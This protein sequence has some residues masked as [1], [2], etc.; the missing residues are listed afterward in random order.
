MRGLHPAAAERNGAD[1]PAGRADLA[2]QPSR[3]DDI[4]DRIPGADFVERH[5]VRRS[6]MHPPLGLGELSEDADGMADG[7]G[8]EGRLFQSIADRSPGYVAVCVVI[9]FVIVGL[10]FMVMMAMM[11]VVM[12][13]VAVI[14][15]VVR[16]VISMADGEAAA[17]EDAVIMGNKRAVDALDQRAKL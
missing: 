2:D 12:I 3:R 13:P 7:F 11:V 8:I 15:R 9:C 10:M 6:P 14:M 17:G 5:V 4:G 1:G 16:P